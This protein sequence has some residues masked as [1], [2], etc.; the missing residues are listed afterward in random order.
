MTEPFLG[1]I[2]MAA[3]NFPPRGYALCDGAMLPI[4][5]NQ[6][7][8]SLLGTM[9]GG[10]GQTTFAL[11]NLRGR[12]PVHVGEGITQGEADGATSVTLSQQQLP[13]HQHQLSARQEDGTTPSPAGT[14]LA[15]TPNQ[16]YHTLDSPVALAEAAVSTTGGSQ[17]HSNMQ[18][19]TVISC[20]IALQGIF[21]SPN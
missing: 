10:D 6:A 3:F 8:F 20:C 14:V 21:P 9:Y 7:L 19:Y 2:T 18:P 4:N 1:Q 12:V 5:Q 11:P 16:I 17:P 15:G 13:A